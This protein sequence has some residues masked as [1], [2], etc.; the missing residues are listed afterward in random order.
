MASCYPDGKFI[1]CD[2]SAPIIDRARK[3]AQQRH[4]DNVTFEVHDAAALPTAWTQTFD[5]VLVRDVIHDLPNT[6]EVLREIRRIMKSDAIFVMA[7]RYSHSC[8][9]DDKGMPGASLLYGCSLF[10]C[11]PSAMNAENPAGLGTMW[12]H[13]KANSVL[14]MSGFSVQPYRVHG[15]F[16]VF[17]SVKN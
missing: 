5:V 2:L 6:Y 9:S 12:G 13:V 14:E 4:W 7:D 16:M 8:A 11:L 1:G 10:N 3:F 15:S 17:V